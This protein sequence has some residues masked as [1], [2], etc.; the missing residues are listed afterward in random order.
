M[1]LKILMIVIFKEMARGGCYKKGNGGIWSTLS[2]QTTRLKNVVDLELI[3]QNYEKQILNV[4]W[5]QIIC[6]KKHIGLIHYLQE[7]RIFEVSQLMKQNHTWNNGRY[8]YK[9]WGWFCHRNGNENCGT[10]NQKI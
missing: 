10:V 4:N 8:W 3:L 9:Q 6:L 2:L 7:V 1:N 5:I